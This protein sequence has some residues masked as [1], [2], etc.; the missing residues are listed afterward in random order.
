MTALK[1]S[2]YL[3]ADVRLEEGFEKDGDV[4]VATRTALYALEIKYGRIAALHAAGSALPAG[5]PI[6]RANGRLALPTMRDMHIHLDKTFYGGPWRAPR[7]RQGK[8]IM[9]MIALEEKLLPQ[10]LPT[11]VERAEGLIALL[12]SKGSTVARSHC[13]IDPVSGLKSLEHLKIALERHRQDFV[14]EIVA[15][16]QHGLLH[17]KVDGL[18]REAMQMGVD[19]VGG[20]D[21]TNVDGAMEKS[22]D[23]MFQIALD[24][25]KGVDIHLH[26]T[27]PAGV[28]AIDYMIDTVEKT[29]ALKG[30]VTI[31]HAFALTVLSPEQLEETAGRPAFS[32]RHDHRLDGADRRPDDAAAEARRKRRLRHDRHR[33]RDRPL[34]A[35]RQR[36]HAGKGLS[37]RAALS[38]VGRVPAVPVAGHFDRR[39]AAARQGRQ[40][41]LAEGWR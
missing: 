14:C 12:Q 27:S 26:E 13:N 34:V 20:L 16:P 36:R 24:A 25:G 15:F 35:L 31:S 17:S 7:P 33:Q 4:I 2:P 30:K 5:L 10:L 38:R 9:D 19:Y 21:P 23:A 40:P 28:A 6:Y 8:T 11:S 29:P 22:L 32:E 37:L 3:L 18:M 39:R 1:D 41:R